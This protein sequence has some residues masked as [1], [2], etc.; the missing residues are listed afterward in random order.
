MTSTMLER[1]VEE[2]MIFDE[3]ADDSIDIVH[4]SCTCSIRLAFCGVLLPEVFTPGDDE[5]LR[6]EACE[7]LENQLCPRCGE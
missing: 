4:I 5:D 3:D 2:D 6:C 7:K 1:P